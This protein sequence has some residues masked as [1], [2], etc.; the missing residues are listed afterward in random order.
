MTVAERSRVGVTGAGG[1]LGAQVCQ[2]LG[3][4]GFEVVAVQ[5]GGP[6]GEGIVRRGDLTDAA[7]AT[8]ALGDC[9]AIVH[10]AARSKDHGTTDEFWKS[11]VVVTEHVIGA[12]ETSTRTPL[13]VHISSTDV[14]GYPVDRS[15]KPVPRSIGL[16]YNATKL[17]AEQ[18]VDRFVSR[19]GDAVV[20]RPSTVYGAGRGAVLESAVTA[21]RTRQ[22]V[23]VDGGRHPAGL[24]HLDDI[25]EVIKAAIDGHLELGRGYDVCGPEPVTWRTYADAVGLVNGLAVTRLSVPFRA[26]Y[27]L[28]ASAERLGIGAGCDG[29]PT[30]HAVLLLGRS[31]QFDSSALGP[32]QPR[33]R[34]M[35]HLSELEWQP[36]PQNIPARKSGS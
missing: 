8:E 34:F 33:R 2:T 26:A 9:D 17:A 30:R 11:N 3:D 23:H 25:V 6:D 14:Y 18:R 36:N 29:S 19:G 22:F 4:R 15:A 13:L 12:A 16:P 21:M 5:R 35:E 28:A 24:V 31:Q 27:L 10:C 20:L 32:H 1:Y 7:F